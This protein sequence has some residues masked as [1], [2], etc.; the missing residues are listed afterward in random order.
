MALSVACASRLVLADIASCLKRPPTSLPPT[1][2][3]ESTFRPTASAWSADGTSLYLASA[4]SIARYDASGAFVKTVYDEPECEDI[5]AIVVSKDKG[6]IIFAAGTGVHFLEHSASAA[7]TSRIVHS[8]PPHPDSEPIIALSLSN[9]N[10]LLAVSSPYAVIVHN[11]SLGSQTLLRGLP[12]DS[13]VTTCAFHPHSRV[14]LFLGIARQL[15]V[16]DITRP[17]GP[18]RIIP[19][20][21]SAVGDI[22]ALSCSPFSKT[23]LAVACAGGHVALIDLDKDKGRIRSYNYGTALTSLIF[24][25]DGATLYAGTESGTLLV[26]SL[27]VVEPPKTVDLG[28]RV[29]CLG[30]T[31]KLKLSGDLSLRTSLGSTTSTR[32]TPHDTSKKEMDGEFRFPTALHRST[33]LLDDVRPEGKSALPNGT[34]VRARVTSES[35]VGR[36]KAFETARS[37]FASVSGESRFNGP[38]TPAMRKASTTAQNG[39]PD[40]SK[41]AGPSFRSP[42][43]IKHSARASS[44]ASPR[45]P[46]SVVGSKP[47]TARARTMSTLSTTARSTI[48]SPTATTTTRTP[49]NIRVRKVSSSASTSTPGTARSPPPR[50][51][52]GPPPAR[53]RTLSTVSRPATTAPTSRATSSGGTSPRATTTRPTSV[54]TTPRERSPVPPVPN[55]PHMGKARMSPELVRTLSQ[56]ST[57]LLRTPSQTGAELLRTPSPGLM[58]ELP[59]F[60]VSVQNTPQRKGL[61]M[62]GMAT[63]EVERW[64]QDGNWKGKGKAIGPVQ[65]Q[66]NVEGDQPEVEPQAADATAE[67]AG[68]G[69]PI[70]AHDDPQASIDD[71]VPVAL[72]VPQVGSSPRERPLSMQLTPRRRKSGTWAPS[73]LRNSVADGSPSRDR[74]GNVQNMLHALVK[75]AMLDFRLENKAQMAGLHLDLIRLGSTWRQEMRDSLQEYMG[76]LHDLR[77]ENKRL[78]E[79][80]ERLRRGY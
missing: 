8:L 70:Q 23:L 46:A 35:V 40:E 28:D 14:R 11:L 45:P 47:I 79:E 60:P 30:V 32:P 9:D 24:S 77:E 44:I 71:A 80:N 6:T 13:A 68:Q 21:D 15:V 49:P 20:S 75:D 57:D 62:L 58:D 12:S 42:L 48:A 69:D 18:S 10:T 34:P 59:P 22:V 2:A 36:K 3:L 31:K 19:M 41:T 25:P 63:P 1:C 74:S 55:L 56:A 72:T 4:H 16:Y 17:L 29:Q 65:V 51:P 52:T 66:N 43:S 27:R 64:I 33:A 38:S 7:S 67:C 39:I 5:R 73:P 61:S 54:N 78:R 53:T 26:Q 50:G 37:L 76:D